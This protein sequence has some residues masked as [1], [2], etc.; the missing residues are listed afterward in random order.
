MEEESK[1]V[2][3]LQKKTACDVVIQRYD[4]LVRHVNAT[5]ILPPLVASKLV[6]PDFSEYLGHER[7]EKDR[8]MAVL[9]ELLRS[10]MEGWFKDFIGALSKF[11]Q[12]KIVV[13]TLL[14][15]KYIGDARTYVCNTR[16]LTET[17]RLPEWKRTPLCVDFTK[18]M[19]E[20]QACPPDDNKRG[21]LPTAKAAASAS[22]PTPKIEVTGVDEV[23]KKALEE[24][25]EGY[26]A[27]LR[28]AQ[29]VMKDAK[30][31]HKAAVRLHY[32]LTP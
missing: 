16:A 22:M 10:P 8:M 12:Y 9:R 29:A 28:E 18:L 17:A 15:G 25:Q 27:T 32:T 4:Y 30:D 7:T 23:M 1:L 2:S 14:T 13:D 6:E 3:R 5:R 26:K 11:P 20:R 24:A 21:M 19:E 31:D